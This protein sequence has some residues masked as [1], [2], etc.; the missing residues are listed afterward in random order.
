MRT[1]R[2]VK[3]QRSSANW[4]K[5]IYRPGGHCSFLDL[6]L[7][8]QPFVERDFMAHR[9]LYLIYN[10]NRENLVSKW[11][12]GHLRE[13]VKF[14]DEND[15]TNDLDNSNDDRRALDKEIDKN[16]IYD[17]VQTE[18]RLFGILKGWVIRI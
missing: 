13:V 4:L 5:L 1:I 12:Q 3:R 9:L 8:F 18:V 17:D 2:N 10:S 15:S 16:N 6:V 7:Q 14:P 11:V